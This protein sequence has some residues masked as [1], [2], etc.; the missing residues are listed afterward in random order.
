MRLK[1]RA[2]FD[3]LVAITCTGVAIYFVFLWVVNGFPIYG[4]D[5]ILVGS[6]KTVFPLL[7][8]A[9]LLLIVAAISVFDFFVHKD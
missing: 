9:I 4:H 6:R 8:P 7:W 1:S 5:E 3:G 2:I